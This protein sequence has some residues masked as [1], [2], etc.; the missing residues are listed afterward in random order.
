MLSVRTINVYCADRLDYAIAP[1]SYP[2]HA[3]YIFGD[4]KH[5]SMKAYRASQL[6]RGIAAMHLSGHASNE[7]ATAHGTSSSPCPV[8]RVLIARDATTDEFLGV[9]VWEVLGERVD[10]D[11]LQIAAP[12]GQL[13]SELPE[14]GPYPV[15]LHRPAWDLFA[16]RMGTAQEAFVK[17][18]DTVFVK[19]LSVAPSAQRRGVGR[20]MMA[21]VFRDAWA[22][23]FES[24]ALQPDSSISLGPFV[25]PNPGTLARPPRPQRLVY[26]D[27]APT[28]GAVP[29]YTSLGFKEMGRFGVPEL[30]PEC[31]QMISMGWDGTL[32]DRA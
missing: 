29:F 21:G 24:S 2:E 30:I 4:L 10:A 1:H 26:L 5:P 6:R 15:A 28:P 13:S 14:I 22:R 18:R 17:G 19:Y 12:R 20:K 16:E 9:I 3:Q 25:F 32:A 31:P 27:A 8:T 7:A 11:V 23:T